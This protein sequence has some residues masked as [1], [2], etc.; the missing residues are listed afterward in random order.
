MVFTALPIVQLWV[1]CDSSREVR[2]T[3]QAKRIRN[4]TILLIA[5]IV[6]ARSSIMAVL[7]LRIRCSRSSARSSR[8]RLYA[9]SAAAPLSWTERLYDMMDVGDQ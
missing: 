3:L 4:H 9:A 8:S 7:S 5:A 6:C 1:N 2:A